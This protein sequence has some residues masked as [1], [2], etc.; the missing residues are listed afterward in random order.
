M[1]GTLLECKKMLKLTCWERFVLRQS[2][3]H[4]GLTQAFLVLFALLAVLAPTFDAPP[5]GN[6]FEEYVSAPA[7]P[8]SNAAVV[9]SAT[10]SVAEDL[11]EEA[12]Q[13][14]AIFLALAVLHGA[15]DAKYRETDACLTSFL[16]LSA[17]SCTG[18]PTTL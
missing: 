5:A 2:R 11:D 3:L 13:E 9:V 7:D 1:A 18:P 10:L 16:R 14:E 6:E 12:D 17:Y 15:P 4:R 8:R